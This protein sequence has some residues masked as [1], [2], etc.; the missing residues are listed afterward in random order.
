MMNI[1]YLQTHIKLGDKDYNFKHFDEYFSRMSNI[2]IIVLPEICNIGYGYENRAEIMDLAEEVK[3]SRT[4]HFFLERAQK[5]GTLIVAGFAERQSSNIYNSALAA[6]PDGQLKIYRKTHLFDREKELFEPGDTGFF[7][8]EF[9]ETKISM[10][11]CFDWSFPET[12]RTLAFQGTQIVCMCSNLVLP[13]KAQKA[14]PVMCMMNRIFAVCAN[15]IGKE[16]DY[17]FTG[18]SLIA[19]PAGEILCESPEDQE[20]FRWVVIDPA[21]SLNKWVTPKN[22]IFLDRKTEFY[23]MEKTE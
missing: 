2:D 7:T 5:L 18:R 6:F 11:I 8:F 14:V 16:R 12:W 22:H 19:N 17:L 10:I 13:G 15:R 23:A 20:E 9:Q 4:I 1:G 21:V 3:N